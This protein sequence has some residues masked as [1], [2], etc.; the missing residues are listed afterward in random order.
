MHLA[1]VLGPN[2]PN[3]KWNNLAVEGACI[4]TM[5]SARLG[6][7]FVGCGDDIL[8]NVNSVSRRAS[9]VAKSRRAAASSP[10][11][12]PHSLTCGATTHYAR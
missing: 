10:S 2:G 7:E 1:L 6:F 11:K 9:P 12:F 8:V 3:T 4:T 5:G